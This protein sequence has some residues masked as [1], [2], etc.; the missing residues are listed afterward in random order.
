MPFS[1]AEEIEFPSFCCCLN[2]S[3]SSGSMFST[4]FGITK[5]MKA[6]INPI[7]TM[8]CFRYEVGSN[9][10]LSSKYCCELLCSEFKSYITEGL[11]ESR[12][13]LGGQEDVKP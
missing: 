13:S 10:S 4:I 3:S 8:G 2:F 5:A 12:G 9:F 11:R 6:T 1:M 7:S